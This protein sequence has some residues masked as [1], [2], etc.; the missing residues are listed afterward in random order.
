[1]FMWLYDTGCSG[2]SNRRIKV[3]K[4]SYVLVLLIEFIEMVLLVLYPHW[5]LLLGST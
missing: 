1:M 5:L 3:V 2:L 4:V